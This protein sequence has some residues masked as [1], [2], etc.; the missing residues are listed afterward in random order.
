MI[1]QLEIANYQSHKSTN[2][3]FHPG[4]NV[5]V[6][7]SDSGKSAVIRALRWLVWNRPIGDS[8]RSDW[9]GDTEIKLMTR[10][11]IIKRIK[12]DDTNT[13]EVN[14]LELASFDKGVPEEVQK[15]LNINEINV[16]GQFDSHF[17]I[18]QSPGEVAR[19]FNKVAKLDQIDLGLKN[20][21]SWIDGAKRD[22]KTEQEE[23][24]ET[25]KKIA[26]YSYLDEAE[27]FM[28]ETERLEKHILELEDDVKEL[29]KILDD[30]SKIDDELAE[31]SHLLSMEDDVDQILQEWDELDNMQSDLEEFDS[32]LTD[33][34]EIEDE[35]QKEEMPEDDGLIDETLKI[36][37]EV[38]ENMKEL[39][40][41]E[42]LITD[43]EKITNL[44]TET[45]ARLIGLQQT[46]RENIGKICPLCGQEIKEK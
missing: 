1:E 3:T 24:D 5:I 28:V 38:T 30:V 37:D 9:G 20:T 26:D 14:G 45:H 16:K 27:E 8:F 4:L 21:K 44:D 19:H 39:N 46:L 34:D 25:K 36:Y 35:L 29:H 7:E 13:Y 22:I 23:L 12:T 31:E 42:N 2:I 41:F 33:I 11:S 43:L 32:L 15:A 40:L 10:E 18:S 17:L 6:G